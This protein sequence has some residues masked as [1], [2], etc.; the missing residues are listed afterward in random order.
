MRVGNVAGLEPSFRG[1]GFAYLGIPR[2]R[3]CCCRHRHSPFYVVG[4]IPRHFSLQRWP[5]LTRVGEGCW[6]LRH[7]LRGDLFSR[8][9]QRSPPLHRLNAAD[10]VV[11]GHWR[12]TLASA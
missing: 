12:F 10:G 5:G 3:T 4:P 1:V 9:Y 6:L 11:L 2:S 7:R 8:R